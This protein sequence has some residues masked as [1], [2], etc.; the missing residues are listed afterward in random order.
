MRVMALAAAAVLVAAGAPHAHAE[1]VDATGVLCAWSG[2]SNPDTGGGIAE[3]DGGPLV[4]TGVEP[5]TPVELLCSLQEYGWHTEPDLAVVRA[6]GR[7]VVAVPPT[8]VGYESDYWV[9]PVV[10]TELRVH[11]SSGDTTLYWDDVAEAWS[12]SPY[13]QCDELWQAEPPDV[14]IDGVVCPVLAVAFP[15][16]GDIPGIW[17]CPPYEA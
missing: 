2:T 3:I 5:G 17:D 16:Q 6:S 13:V 14:W 9:I 12:T 1:P 10:C 4:V 11:E 7:S 15:P 8:V